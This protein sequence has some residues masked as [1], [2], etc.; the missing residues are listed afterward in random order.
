MITQRGILVR[1]LLVEDN[2]IMRQAFRE[3]LELHGY[4]VYEARSGREALT[5]ID[6]QTECFD[7]VISDL[8]MP[9]M[10]AL[11]LYEALEEVQGGVRM[12]IITGYPMPSTG[13]TLAA[14]P[15]VSWVRKPVRFE[16]LGTIV[17]DLVGTNE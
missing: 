6:G 10:N 7:M 11:E 16:Q 17:H 2:D 4:D 3:A 15:G 14:R 13:Q 5:L 8:V 12:L 1:I 9:H